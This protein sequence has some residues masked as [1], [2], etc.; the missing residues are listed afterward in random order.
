MLRQLYV[1]VAA[2]DPEYTQGTPP[3]YIPEADYAEVVKT[4]SDPS[5]A[6]PFDVKNMAAFYGAEARQGLL[7]LPFPYLV[8]GGRFNSMFGW[9]TAFAVFA[10][11]NEHP[12]MIREQVDNHLYQIRIYGKVLNANRT[13]YLSRS[14]PPLIAAMVLSVYRAAEGR[15][16]R[17]FDPNGLYADAKD[18][19]TH[20]LSALVSYYDYW[21]TG[22]RLAD[23]GPLS[24]YWDDSDL[25][26]PEV[27]EGENGHFDHARAHFAQ[28]NLPA[29]EQGNRDL[30]Y[31]VKT[32]DLTPLY[33]RADRV[34]RASGLD[35]TGHWSYGALRCMLH[36]PVCVNALL[37]R[38]EGEM[39]EMLSILSRPEAEAAVWKKRQSLR[40]A[41]MRKYMF[42]PA[43]GLYEDYDFVR[44]V[45]NPKPF[46]TAFHAF[47]AG[48]YDDDKA[49]AR[50][51]ADSALEFLE[52]PYG[53]VT[54]T[55]HSGSQWD[56]PYGWPPLQY[57]AFAGLQRCG[58]D[59]DA[60]RIAGNFGGVALKVFEERGSLYEK[61][62]LRDGNA[63]IKVVHGY[64]ENVAENGTFLW[65]AAVLK[66][67][68]SLR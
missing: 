8:P 37:Y 21:T 7:Y 14:Q 19:L 20:A 38:M 42:N 66:M 9:D 28:D 24:R 3:V 11:A 13:Y 48:L 26:A 32:R 62:N 16:W 36:A 1:Q 10:W 27:L 52:T 54:S 41:A 58:F 33:Y 30:F 68:G 59:D 64:H 61:Y 12:A 34:M 47:W 6:E 18:W 45:R 22:D 50:K 31:D 29:D 25:P 5:I 63:D 53:I 46:A 55:Q 40:K 44:K 57:F 60:R 2:L 67:A 65:T 23:G 35:P 43:T 15:N 17:E 39:A 51:A 4:L 56:Y 49:V